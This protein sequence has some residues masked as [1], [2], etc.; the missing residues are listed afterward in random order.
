MLVAL[1]LK[2]NIVFKAFHIA[3]KRN[4]IADA[5]SRLQIKRLKELAPKADF[6]PTPESDYLW[7]QLKIGFK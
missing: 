3:G 6:F 1:C 2:H 5:L 7:Q 4:A